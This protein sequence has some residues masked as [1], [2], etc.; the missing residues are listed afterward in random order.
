MFISK[1]FAFFII[2]FIIIL[3]LAACGPKF[4]EPPTV[5]SPNKQENPLNEE[6]SLN[7]ERTV[8][9]DIAIEITLDELETNLKEL[10]QEIS[11]LDE[12]RN[13]R[14]DPTSDANE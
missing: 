5:L 7:N 2:V 11:I 13:L 3:F 6:K 9:D 1:R 4:S 8:P 14:L 10:E 12:L